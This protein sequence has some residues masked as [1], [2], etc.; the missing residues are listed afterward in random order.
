M[1][2]RTD[3]AIEAKELWRESADETTELSGV[4]AW[5]EVIDGVK[6]TIVKVLDHNGEKQLGKPIGTYVTMDLEQMVRKEQDGFNRV[7]KA[8]SEILRSMAELK[9]GDSVLVVGLGNGNITPDAVG[10]V[11]LDYLM[12]TRHLVHKAPEYFAH[13]RQV[14]AIAPGVLGT[15]G[16]ESAEIIKGVSERSRPDLIVVID[17][18]VSRKL[19]RVCTT[20]QLADTGIVPGSG[21]GNSRVALNKETLGVPVIAVGVPTVVDAATLA[22]DLMEQAGMQVDSE[23]LKN[24]GGGMIVTPKDIDAS[25]QDIA[26]VIGY[27]LNLA[28]H[29][30]MGIDDVTMFIS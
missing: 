23:V 1:G 15:T 14:S 5:D 21:I 29:E 18:L 6:T 11:S 25:I 24:D 22:A 8:I 13:F 17:A 7:V 10:P 26:K 2:R 30:G 19:S 20:V 12:V 3:L 27:S 4:K 9:D 28:F 16:L